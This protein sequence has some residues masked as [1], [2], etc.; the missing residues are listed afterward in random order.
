MSASLV[1]SEMCIRDSPSR[2]LSLSLPPFPLSSPLPLPSPPRSV[3]TFLRARCLSAASWFSRCLPALLTLPR[4]DD[5][6][7]AP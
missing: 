7:G 1:G 3:L 2:L 4:R 6:L 5:G